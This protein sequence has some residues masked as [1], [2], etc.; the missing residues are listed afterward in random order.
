MRRLKNIVTS[1][2][3]GKTLRLYFAATLSPHVY[4]LYSSVGKKNEKTGT[5]KNFSL[6]KLHQ[7]MIGEDHWLQCFVVE[8]LVHTQVSSKIGCVNL[9]ASLSLYVLFLSFYVCFLCAY[10]S[11][12]F[13]F[14]VLCLC[15]D[16]SLMFLFF[17]WSLIPF[18]SFSVSLFNCLY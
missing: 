2:S 13:G 12:Y 16:D 6:S 1:T 9:Y 7:A 5:K 3:A 17:S 15:F 11:L 14:F 18:D 8:N 4:K 10:I